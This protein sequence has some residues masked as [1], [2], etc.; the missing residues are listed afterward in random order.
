M[1]L[2]DMKI[3]TQLRIGMSVIILFVAILGATA[4]FQAND[5]WQETKGLYEHP[6]TVR[7][8]LDKLT[9]DILTMHR[10]MKDLVM[11]DNE[12]ERQSIILD[13]DT[14][15]AEA[16]KQFDILYDRYLGPRKDIEEARSA[17]VLW[18]AIRVETIR[19]L[20]AGKT[21]EAVRRT[22]SSGIGGGHVEKLLGEIQDMSDF[23]KVRGDKF[24]ADA[25]KEKDALMI[26]LWIVFG[27]ILLLTLGVSYLLLRNI[28]K[29]LQ[30]LTSLT[31]QFGQGKLDA[32]SHYVSAN[33][34]GN[35]AVSYNAL[36]ETVQSEWQSR[37]SAARI[38][39]V[40]LKQE[41]MRDFCKAL[42]KNLLTETGSQIG[43]IYILNEQKTDFEHFES[44]GLAGSGRASF[45]ATGFEG[46]FGA[47]LATGQIQHISDIPS[48]S[49][50]TFASVGGDFKPR[51]IITIP[52]SGEGEIA[53]VIS[54]ASIRGYSPPAVRLVKEIWYVLTARWNGVLSFRKIRVFAEQLERQN[55]ELQAQQEEL[56]AQAEELRKQT[57]ELQQQNVE[58][59]QQRQAVEEANRLKSQFLSNMSHELRT[60]LNSVMALSRVLMMQA[61]T[62]L[63]AEEVN[64]L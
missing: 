64:Y 27:A 52:I 26:R 20:G 46:E 38:A 51:E 1:K 8:A 43:A 58:L 15:E 28:R 14:H 49:R 41:D 39:E 24:Y 33:E 29:P 47:A 19:L 34:F 44:L 11:A 35:L 17:F 30:E 18:K 63:S 57:E 50:F 2:K 62:K 22:K 37:E 5:L 48:D 31:E 13:I 59:D 53:A 7:R 12:Q 54:L 21:T 6:L 55:Q 40:M 60:P 4:W 42:L 23:A 25:Q 56:E 36:A 16:T 10:D 32:R 61:K 3:S 9:I 45:S